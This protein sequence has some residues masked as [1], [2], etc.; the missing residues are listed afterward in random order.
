MPN[1]W[2]AIIWTNADPI[3]WH[4]YA[5]LGGEIIHMGLQTMHYLQLLSDLNYLFTWWIVME[6]DKCGFVIIN[7]FT[8]IELLFMYWVMHFTILYH[9]FKISLKF[10]LKGLI[11]SPQSG[12]TVIYL[13]PLPHPLPQRLLPLMSNP[14]V[15]SLRYLGQRRYWSGEMYWV[16]FLWPW[17]KAMAVALIKEMC[18]PVQL[19]KNH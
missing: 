12:V 10:V 13:F 11:K 1:R 8:F 3:H 15:L 14:F 18:L 4:I 17:P 5:T 6:K 2:Q 16:T 7:E 9:V 19:S